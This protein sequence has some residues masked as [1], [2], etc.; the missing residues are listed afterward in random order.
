MLERVPE[1]ARSDPRL[2]LRNERWFI[3]RL[4][5]RRATRTMPILPSTPRAVQPEDSSTPASR[6]PNPTPPAPPPSLR[7]LPRRS[8]RHAPPPRSP[9]PPPDVQWHSPSPPQTPTAAARAAALA[10]GQYI[11]SRMAFDG[12]ADGGLL[13]QSV[14]SGPRSALPQ[15]AQ[16]GSKPKLTRNQSQQIG[17]ASCRERV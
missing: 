7:A 10:E 12:L 9:P 17:R 14:V 13:P 15:W 8:R 1:W 6:L 5:P 3:G 4:H 16:L 11:M 2:C